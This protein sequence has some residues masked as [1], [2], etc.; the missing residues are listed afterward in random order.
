M[1]TLE[2]SLKHFCGAR[3]NAKRYRWIRKQRELC[4]RCLSKFKGPPTAQSQILASTA[5]LI[6][7]WSFDKQQRRCSEK[8]CLVVVGWLLET[9][10]IGHLDGCYFGRVCSFMSSFNFQFSSETQNIQTSQVIIFI[11]PH[12]FLKTSSQ[13]P[14]NDQWNVFIQFHGI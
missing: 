6:R 4:A 11:H 3:E 7:K 8:V 13:K 9:F 5:V 12:S 14:L 2:R 10:S 1:P